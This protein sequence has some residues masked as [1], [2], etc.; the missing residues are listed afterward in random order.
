MNQTLEF[1]V[2]IVEDSEEG[3][4]VILRMFDFAGLTHVGWCYASYIILLNLVADG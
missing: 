4:G 2:S 1:G 3:V